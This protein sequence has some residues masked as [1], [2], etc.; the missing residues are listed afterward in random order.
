MKSNN[1]KAFKTS[2]AINISCCKFIASKRK[3]CSISSI[4]SAIGLSLYLGKII[5][6][7]TRLI[8]VFNYVVDGSSV[9]AAI[10]KTL[11]FLLLP[12]PNLL[13]SPLSIR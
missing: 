9:V 1:A 7:G 10:I 2:G 5:F 11:L 6:T 3:N 8:N 13:Y 12:S 4:F